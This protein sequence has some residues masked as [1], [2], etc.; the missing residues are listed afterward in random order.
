MAS[1]TVRTI[2]MREAPFAR[3]TATVVKARNKSMIATE[4]VAR[5]A[6]SLDRD[7]HSK[8]KPQFTSFCHTCSAAGESLSMWSGNRVRVQICSSV[9]VV[10]HEGMPVQRMP[11]LIFQKEKPWGS[12]LYAVCRQLRRPRVKVLRGQ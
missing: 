8:A 7:F 12:V 11:C 2:R 10:F 6:P 3:A 4:R 9:S 5:M 1:S